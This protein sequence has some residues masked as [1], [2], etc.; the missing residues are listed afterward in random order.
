MTNRLEAFKPQPA[1][2]NA[3]GALSKSEAAKFVCKFVRMFS[4]L[5]GAQRGELVGFC[6]KRNCGALAQ[7][8]QNC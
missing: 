7:F 8:V 2:R 5:A 6:A 4:A 3:D 1:V